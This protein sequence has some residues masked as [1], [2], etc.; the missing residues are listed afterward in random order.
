MNHSPQL[1]EVLR[2]HF[3]PLHH[4]HWPCYHCRHRQQFPATITANTVKIGTYEEVYVPTLAGCPITPNKK[5][6]GK[7]SLSALTAEEF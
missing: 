6:E 5:E 7:F 4:Y 3:P 2:H 1:H